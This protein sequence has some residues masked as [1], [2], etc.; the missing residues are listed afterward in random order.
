MNQNKL[1][2]DLRRVPLTDK[3]LKEVHDAIHNTVAGKMKKFA[4]AKEKKKAAKKT[5]AKKPVKSK[6]AAA[7][8]E[9]FATMAEAPAAA[10]ATKTANISVKFTNTVPGKSELTAIF[11]DESKTLTQ[12]GKITFAGVNSADMIGIQGK[13][14]GTTTVTIDLSADPMQMNFGPGHFNDNF[15]IN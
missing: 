11:N 12:T 4:A 13:S 10:V 1:T 9:S 14:L 6:K 7:G 15:F 5:A 3:E 8:L 2:I